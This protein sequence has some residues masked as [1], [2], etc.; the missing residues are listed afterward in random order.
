[1]FLRKENCESWYAFLH[2]PRSDTIRQLQFATVVVSCVH[3][4][5]RYL[6]LAI[7]P[8][9]LRVKGSGWKT[10]MRAAATD[11]RVWID[12]ML[13]VFV[14]M[15]FVDHD[16]Y[17]DLW[18]PTFMYMWS[19]KR[20]F[21]DVVLMCVVL[22]F[23]HLLQCLTVKRGLLHM[24]TTVRLYCLTMSLVYNIP[25]CQSYLTE[26]SVC[27]CA[28]VCV[29]CMCVCV[30]VCVCV[31]SPHVFV[32]CTHI[33]YEHTHTHTHTHTHKRLFA[34][35]SLRYL[36]YFPK[37]EHIVGIILR[38]VKLLMTFITLMF[39]CVFMVDRCGLDASWQDD[40]NL[41]DA[42][43]FT[44]TTITTVGYGDLVP[45]NWQGKMIVLLMFLYILVVL[46]RL[47]RDLSS[48][49]EQYVA[50]FQEC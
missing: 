36:R 49:R 26:S 4:L 43:W 14:L 28:C 5:L 40:T 45:A 38:T 18:T 29:W 3:T 6:T 34:H 10:V 30:C 8:A 23:S 24:G 2:Q 31:S 20:A 17:D 47:L 32:T 19:L 50:I 44:L 27:L 42:L 12:I 35:L 33:T 13:L 21:R 22:L 1:M 37:D 48:S 25:F 7:E 9:E 11:E 15:P 16:K 41:F 46:P 39:T